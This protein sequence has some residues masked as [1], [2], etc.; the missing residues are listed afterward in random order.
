VVRYFY[1]K[2]AL[3]TNGAINAP[4]FDTYDEV[5]TAAMKEQVSYSALQSITI[6]KEEFTPLADIMVSQERVVKMRGDS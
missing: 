1:S 6:Y 5:V 2:T 4:R 3:N